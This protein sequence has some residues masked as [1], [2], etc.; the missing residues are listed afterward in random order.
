MVCFDLSLPPSEQQKQIEYWLNY[1]NSILY[2]ALRQFSPSSA[3]TTTN[4]D[5]A[6]KWKIIIVGTRADLNKHSTSSSSTNGFVESL[7]FANYPFLPVHNSIFHISTKKDTSFFAS[8]ADLCETIKTE[9]LQILEEH[10]KHV[11]CAFQDLRDALQSS[12]QHI[13][14]ESDIAN[15]QPRWANEPLLAP[16]L[17]FLQSIGEIVQFGEGRICT[18]PLVISQ[19]L[20]KFICSDEHREQVNPIFSK[21]RLASI[22]SIDEELMTKE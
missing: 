3:P 15:I 16:A 21:T 6:T 14:H 1:L 17:D 10:T 11:P 12:S 9:C 2:H 8:L 20:A 13:L 5:V 19:V 7:S 18:K 22:R 4:H